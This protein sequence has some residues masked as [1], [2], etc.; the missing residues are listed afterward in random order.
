MGGNHGLAIRCVHGSLLIPSQYVHFGAL[1]KCFEE[2]PF[3]AGETTHVQIWSRTA[4]Y[5]YDERFPVMY[6]KGLFCVTNSFLQP[7]YEFYLTGCVG[8]KKYSQI[9]SI[10]GTLQSYEQRHPTELSFEKDAV[11][12]VVEN[13]IWNTRDG[14]YRMGILIDK[15]G[16]FKNRGLICENHFSVR[17]SF[18]SRGVLGRQTFFDNL[19]MK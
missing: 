3:L 17:N 18:D 10:I 4:R 5:N 9:I 12:Y 1:G 13:E 19:P 11:M 6:L 14:C 16:K 2:E 7:E 8:I 15:E